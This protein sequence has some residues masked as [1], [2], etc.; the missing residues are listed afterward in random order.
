[1]RKMSN[2]A[3][4]PA[5]QKPRS[6]SDLTDQSEAGRSGCPKN[7]RLGCNEAEFVEF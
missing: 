2:A 4:K 5:N 3:T 7:E 6:L 1:M